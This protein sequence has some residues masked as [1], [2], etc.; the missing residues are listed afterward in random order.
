MKRAGEAEAGEGG[1]VSLTAPGAA[2]GS[3]PSFA[4][5]AAAAWPRRPSTLLDFLADVGVGK[6]AGGGRG[7]SAMVASP[8]CGC[9]CDGGLSGER[10]CMQKINR[11]IA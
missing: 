7:G 11:G 8:A 4:A 2:G 9:G 10:E 5:A 1:G 3:I 6:G